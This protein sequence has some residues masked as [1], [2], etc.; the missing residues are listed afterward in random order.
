[1][2]WA[3]R[4]AI[5]LHRNPASTLIREVDPAEHVEVSVS[6]PQSVE[7]VEKLTPS[8]LLAFAAQYG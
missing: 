3:A 8:Q 1:M 5:P 4:G 7:D 2:C 6:M